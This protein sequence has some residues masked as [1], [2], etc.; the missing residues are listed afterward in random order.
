[1]IIIIIYGD[2]ITVDYTAKYNK[3]SPYKVLCD[4]GRRVPRVYKYNGKI[5]AIR[6]DL[7]K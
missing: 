7:I 6:D 3:T 4:I 5:I 2:D 1:M